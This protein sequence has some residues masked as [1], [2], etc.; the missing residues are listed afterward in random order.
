MDNSTKKQVDDQ[1]QKEQSKETKPVFTKSKHWKDFMTMV[2]T[3]TSMDVVEYIYGKLVEESAPFDVNELW[4]H[5]M[6]PVYISGVARY[7]AHL[8][9]DVNHIIGSVNSTPWMR[10]IWHTDMP[11]IELFLV[12]YNCNVSIMD[13]DG[14][15]IIWYAK[16]KD[17]VNFVNKC[18]AKRKQIVD[19]KK[20][21][22]DHEL[23][24]RK[25]HELEET[26]QSMGKVFEKRGIDWTTLL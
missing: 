5:F 8:G 7:I 6:C 10:A 14:D 19:S 22:E 18:L 20:Q 2:K 23:L 1:G 21:V 9:A 4:G 16:K 24:K 15:D 3:D 12:E 17:L 25:N 13:C 11:I 26:I